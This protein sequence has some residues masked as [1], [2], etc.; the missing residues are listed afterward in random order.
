MPA[1]GIRNNN[2]GNN[3]HTG[4][5]WQGMADEQPDPNFVTFI[6]PE[7]GIRAIVRILR[8]Y[9]KRGKN[10]IRQYIS[11]WAPPSENN[12][13]AYVQSVVNRVGISADVEV[14]LDDVLPQLVE[15]ITQHENGEQPYSPDMITKG[16]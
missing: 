13:E 7:Y 16:I 14:A 11:T 10:T 3:R 15:A 4:A 9:T 6:A 12:T 1:R 8:S 2:P 5:R